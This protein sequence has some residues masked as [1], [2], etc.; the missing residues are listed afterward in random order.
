MST[1]NKLLQNRK[2]S[3]GSNRSQSISKQLALNDGKL[4]SLNEIQEQYKKVLAQ[5]H[6]RSFM[7][8]SPM[9]VS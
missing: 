7:S 6:R 9:N 3:V 1:Q 2:L 4:I 8:R 5:K